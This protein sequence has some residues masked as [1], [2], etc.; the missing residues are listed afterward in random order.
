MLFS[1]LMIDHLK[2]DLY[3]K[4]IQNECLIK[5]N[6]YYLMNYFDFKLNYI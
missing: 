3:N 2:D 1:N 6:T 4:S 5:L